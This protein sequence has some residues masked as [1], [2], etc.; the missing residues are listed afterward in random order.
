M[1]SVKFFGKRRPETKSA[2]SSW[3]EIAYKPEI[4][5]RT[6]QLA[7]LMGAGVSEMPTM[8]FVN[9]YTGKVDQT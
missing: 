3:E 1:P 8:N 9:A 2:Q 4:E 6:P 5:Y 7:N